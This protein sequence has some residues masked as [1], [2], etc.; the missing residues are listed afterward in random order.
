MK[1]FVLSQDWWRLLIIAVVCYLIGCFNF[2]I[3][4]SKLKKSDITKRGSGNPGTMNMTREFG[5]KIGVITFFC[6]AFKG[7]IPALI[8]FFVYKN[9]L[10]A[11]TSVAV[12]DFIRYFCGAFVIIGH[13]FP[14]TMKFKGGKG[15]ASTLGL[16][17][18]SLAC[19]NAWLLPIG[20]LFLVFVASYIVVT[21]WGSMGS[22]IGVSGFA[23]W[24]GVIF[25]L[26]Y[27]NCLTSPFLIA[28]FCL[29]FF[30][31]VVTWGAH[32][33]NIVRL[34]SGEEHRTSVK[35][36]VKKKD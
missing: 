32:H 8:G 36:M 18:L 33:K 34:V 16:F 28:T 31:V 2:A 3:L 7:G 22:L 6:D 25:R 4:I 21:E 19:E 24:Q 15:I 30:I 13:V 20:F 14:V 23:V 12:S 27:A 26:R 35:K 10:F 29:T 5:M 11:G 17:W 9:Y 1:E